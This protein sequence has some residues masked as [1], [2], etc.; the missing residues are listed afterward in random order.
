MPLYSDSQGRGKI[1]HNGYEGTKYTEYLKP[2]TLINYRRIGR[3]AGCGLLFSVVYFSFCAKI[4]VGNS[5]LSR[6]IRAENLEKLQ[7]EDAEV[8]TELMARGK[9]GTAGISPVERPMATSKELL[10]RAFPDDF[11]E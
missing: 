7:E 8:F 9:I 6:D 4:E 10:K 2:K 11:K 3:F 5:R 1:V